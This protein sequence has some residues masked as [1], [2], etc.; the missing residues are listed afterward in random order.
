MPFA[1]EQSLAL[2]D[3]LVVLLLRSRSGHQR[4]PLKAKQI[5]RIERALQWIHEHLHEEVRVGAVAAQVGLSPAHFRELFRQ[6]EGISPK[7][8]LLNLRLETAKS[9]LV[10]SER[11]VATISDDVGFGDYRQFAK[12]FK[13]RF[14]LTPTEWR[15]TRSRA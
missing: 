10:D 7:Q 13:R 15:K 9:F 14:G 1:L 4:S 3:Q 12:A 11:P 5:A 6:H 8:Y 2:L